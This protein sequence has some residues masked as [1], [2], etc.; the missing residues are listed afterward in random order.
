MIVASC[1]ARVDASSSEYPIALYSLSFVS[2]M[3]RAPIAT[4]TASTNALG[5]IPY[6][7]ASST[8]LFFHIFQSESVCISLESPA[9]LLFHLF[10]NNGRFSIDHFHAF[11]GVR[12]FFRRMSVLASEMNAGIESSCFIAV[13]TRNDIFAAVT[14]FARLSAVLSIESLFDAG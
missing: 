2:K 14:P 13:Y 1:F 7:L 12:M 5:D 6:L 10:S 8:T 11:Q 9:C 4:V 3:L